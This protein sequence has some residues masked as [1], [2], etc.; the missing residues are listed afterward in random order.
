VSAS[1]ASIA[2]E[3]ASILARLLQSDRPLAAVL[4]DSCASATSAAA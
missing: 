2:I 1:G 3:D 4:D